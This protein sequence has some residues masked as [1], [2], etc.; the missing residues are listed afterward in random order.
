ML[1]TTVVSHD[2]LAGAFPLCIAAPAPWW[3][4]EDSNLRRLSQQIY[5]LPRLTASVPL[6]FVPTK[7]TTS[8]RE[9]PIERPSTHV[10]MDDPH[11]CTKVGDVAVL[12]PAWPTR[13]ARPDYGFGIRSP[14][15]PIAPNAVLD[16]PSPA[17]DRP[18]SGAGDGT[19]TRNLLI[20]NQLLYPLSYASQNWWNRGTLARA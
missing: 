19:R 14:L 12:A 18:R 11:T 1:S 20:T 8:E 15:T 16:L 13:L 10:A 9:T 4:G 3:R 2:P 7:I 17:K 6:R 5:S